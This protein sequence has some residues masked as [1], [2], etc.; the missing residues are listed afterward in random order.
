M[1][2]KVGVYICKGCEIASSID[3]DKLVTVATGEYHVPVCKTHDAWCSAE[4]I[5]TIRKDVETEGLNRVV[6]A[7]CSQR[8][9][10][11]LFVFGDSVLTERANIR[12][13]GAWAHEPN[14]E[15]TQMLV[16]DY[17]RMG[18]VKVQTSEPAV[19]LIEETSKD[20][21]VIGGGMTGLTAARAAADAGYRVHLVEKEPQLGGWARSFSRVFP[22]R[23]PYRQLQDSGYPELVKAV[24]THDNI[25]VHTNSQIK[26]AKGAPGKFDVTLRNGSDAPS[27]KVGAMVVA[28]GWTPYPAEKLSHLGY[29]SS[30]NIITNVKMEALALS[31]EMKRPSDNKPI[32]SIAFIQCAGSRDQ[33]HLPYCSTVCCR[34]SLKQAMYVREKYPDARIYVIYKDIR[35]PQQYELFYQ[36]AQTDDG[37]FLTKGEIGSVRP[38]GDQ[39]AIDVSETLLGEDITI[40]AD[41]VVLATGM[42]TT[43]KPDDI[44]VAADAADEALL[45][46]GKKAAA[47]A[48]KGAHLINLGYRQGTDLPTLKYGFPDSHF[49]CFPY[50]TRRTGIYA[51]G[52]VR[53]PMD[54]AAS[55]SDAYGAALKAIQAVEAISRGSAV[56]PRAGDSSF[57]D[58]FMTKCTQCKRCTEECPFGALDEDEKG[59]PLPNPT[60]CRRCGVCLGACPERIISFKNYSVNMISKMIKSISMPDEFDEKPRILAFV[61]END[62]LPSV[63]MAGIKRMK[64]SPFVRIIPLR[65]LGS[66]NAVWVSDALASGFDGIILIGCKRGDDYQCHFIRG[67]ELANY[68]MDNVR[69][70]LTQLVLEE[71]RVQIVEL[72][73]NEYYKLPNIFD[74]FVE[75]ISGI[76]FNPYKGM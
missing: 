47:G 70:K 37:M 66:M 61:C 38:D 44:P 34:V 39:I 60:R 58:F 43:N 63:D 45:E 16:E 19:P 20:I 69:E 6:V 33:D 52:P 23:P 36:H 5:Q 13:Y 35:S 40:K 15:D 41:M 17:L 73:I 42:V 30:P 25:V 50:E 24:E 26:S 2:T 31:G 28:T 68:R 1:D 21:L 67:S 64:Y 76:G 27:F 53:S 57:P 46:D 56:H 32:G 10:P 48:E 54:F 3:V 29:G 55:V 51:A 11:E 4:G 59:T 65:C 22:K 71:E 8:V 9:F 62:A 18:I 72:A 75:E 49:I 14:D 7:A 12:E 74:D